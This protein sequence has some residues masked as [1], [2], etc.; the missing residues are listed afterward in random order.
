[1]TTRP[2]AFP[3]EDGHAPECLRIEQAVES[4]SEKAE[5]SGR[6][7]EIVEEAAARRCDERNAGGGDPRGR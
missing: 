3:G 7:G 5:F 6:D 4:G 1:M 2:G